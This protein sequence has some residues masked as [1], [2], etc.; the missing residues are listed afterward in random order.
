MSMPPLRAQHWL[1][2]ALL[3]G[4]FFAWGAWLMRPQPAAQPLPWLAEWQTKV[5]TPLADDRLSLVHL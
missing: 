1:L 2:F 4:L 5:L 3:A